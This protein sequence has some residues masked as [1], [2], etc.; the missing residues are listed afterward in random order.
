MRTTLVLLYFISCCLFV[1]ATL[2]R[3]D[4]KKSHKADPEVS[5]FRSMR[6]AFAARLFRSSVRYRTYLKFLLPCHLISVTERCSFCLWCRCSDISSWVVSVG[7]R[8]RCVRPALERHSEG[9]KEVFYSHQKNISR[10]DSGICHTCKFL[11]NHKTHPHSHLVF[12]YQMVR[13]ALTKRFSFS[14]KVLINPYCWL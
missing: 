6:Q 5:N 9:G 1:S 7:E 14:N 8:P 4:A 13:A 2:S 12:F 11:S 10:A 3:T